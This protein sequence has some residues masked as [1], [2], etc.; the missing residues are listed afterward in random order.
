MYDGNIWMATENK[1]MLLPW[2]LWLGDGAYVMCPQL[3]CPYC[4]PVLG[5]LSYNQQLMNAV[6]SHYRARVEHKNKLLER[7]NILGTRFRG[8][9]ELLM[10]AGEVFAKTENIDSKMHLCYR[11]IGPFPHL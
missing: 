5:T 6:I 7:H 10:D 4:H 9:C 8:G 3:L 11:P 2:E 1:H